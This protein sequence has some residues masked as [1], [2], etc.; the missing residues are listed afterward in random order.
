MEEIIL[1]APDGYVYRN[2]LNLEIYGTRISLGVNDLE[3]NW[4]LVEFVENIDNNSPI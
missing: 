4:E 3:E 1:I 2:I